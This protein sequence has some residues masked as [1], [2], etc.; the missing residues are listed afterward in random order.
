MKGLAAIAAAGLMAA[1]GALWFQTNPNVVTVKVAS[2]Q[3]NAS[4]PTF[5]QVQDEVRQEKMRQ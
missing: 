2:M 5:K 1:A 3:P 4:L